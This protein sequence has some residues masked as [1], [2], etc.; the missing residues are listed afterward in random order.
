MYGVQ[1]RYR[2]KP[3]QAELVL[4]N[5]KWH[6]VFLEEGEMPVRGQSLVVYDGDVCLGGGIIE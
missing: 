2:Q 6:V 1:T 4:N 5:D 3:V